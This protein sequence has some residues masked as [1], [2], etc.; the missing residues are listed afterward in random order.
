MTFDMLVITDKK[1]AE[2]CSY[3]ICVERPDDAH[4]HRASGFKVILDLVGSLSDIPENSVLIT[5]PRLSKLLSD[6]YVRDVFDSLRIDDTMISSLYVC[7]ELRGDVVLRSASNIPCGV[8][9]KNRNAVV[10]ALKPF[11]LYLYL[12]PKTLINDVNVVYNY[13]VQKICSFITDDVI[14]AVAKR[15]A[16]YVIEERKD[17]KIS[18]IL[19]QLDA[20]ARGSVSEIK[21]LPTPI[22][23]VL[24]EYG[25]LS[26][27][28]ICDALYKV[29]RRVRDH[30]YPRQ[31]SV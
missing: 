19:S 17:G 3:A 2:L 9:I 27:N 15:I 5:S 12:H 21:N 11:N 23:D 31:S 16:D 25:L 13:V 6:I 18:K 8:Y 22:L 14:D 24:E 29:I 26:N 28:M 4:R 1:S 7:G 30:V 10:L 20:V